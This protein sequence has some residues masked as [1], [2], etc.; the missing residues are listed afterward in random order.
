MRDS[1]QLPDANELKSIL[2]T[3][4]KRDLPTEKINLHY[5]S[6]TS[7]IELSE[8]FNCDPELIRRNL[9]PE[10]LQNDNLQKDADQLIQKLTDSILANPDRTFLDPVYDYLA[11]QDE[12][13]KADAIFVFG[14][15]T[16]LRAEKAIELYKNGWSKQIVFSGHGPFTGRTNDITEAE[17]YRDLAVAAGVPDQDIIL[18]TNS[19][20]IPDNV[21]SGLN[22]FDQINFHPTKLILVNSPYVQRRGWCHFQK[23]LPENIEV[24]RHNCGTGEKFSRD[25]WFTNPEGIKI[26]LNEFIKMR[27]AVILNTA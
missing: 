6:F 15:K 24:I 25:G 4:A 17:I 27:I 20:T 5:P 16:P 23:Y 1:S 10:D 22:L 9:E 12:L 2:D 21:R 7:F 13:K 18:E 19:I 11:E 3:E 8:F 14:A 26:V